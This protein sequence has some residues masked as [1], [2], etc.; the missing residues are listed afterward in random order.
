[1]TAKERNLIQSTINKLT[2]LDAERDRIFKE[3]QQMNADHG[4][5]HKWCSV[6]ANLEGI[7]THGGKDQQSRALWLY[8]RYFEAEAKKDLLR[9][10][11]Q[12]LADLGFWKK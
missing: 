1:M 9:E 10:L 8:R 2:A 6:D 11:G 5:G 3:L 7:S 4:D 12:G